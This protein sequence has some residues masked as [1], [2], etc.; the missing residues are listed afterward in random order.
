MPHHFRAT[1][2][3]RGEKVSQ[4]DLDDDQEDHGHQQD[5]HDDILNPGDGPRQAAPRLPFSL[6]LKARFS[7][8]FGFRSTKWTIH[9]IPLVDQRVS[10]FI[11]VSPPVF[12]EKRERSVQELLR[13]EFPHEA[14][15]DLLCGREDIIPVFGILLIG[16]YDM[17]S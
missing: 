3:P 1:G 17:N 8:T 12:G 4:D 16:T 15:A 5:C 14:L 6:A 2:D 13:V 10:G 11:R 7:D 9:G